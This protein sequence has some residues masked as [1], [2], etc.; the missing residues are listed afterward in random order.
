MD[1][2]QNLIRDFKYNLQNSINNDNN[3]PDDDAIPNTSDEPNLALDDTNANVYNTLSDDYDEFKKDIMD[4]K[5]KFRVEERQEPENIYSITLRNIYGFFFNRFNF[6]LVMW[7]LAIFFTIYGFLTIFTKTDVVTDGLLISR[8]V[9]FITFSF[10]FI[11]IFHSY[12]SSPPEIQSDFLYYSSELFRNELKDFNTMFYVT[13]FIIVLYIFSFLLGIPTGDEK[14]YSFTLLEN[15]AWVYLVLLVIINF[16]TYILNVSIVDLV[17]KYINDLFT[18]K[19]PRTTPPPTKKPV[20]YTLPPPTSPPPT[21][22][23]PTPSP[24]PTDPPDA[25]VFNI[26]NNLYTYEDAKNV[27]TALDARL[28]TY[29]QIEEAYNDGAE[30]CNYGWSTDQMA[31]FPTQ[32]DTWKK[33]QKNNG[34]KVN[35]NCGRPGI[36]GGFMAN[37][38]LK[39]GVNCFGKKPLPKETDL[40]NMNKPETQPQTAE[41]SEFEAKIKYWKENSD[42][43]L[44]ISGFNKNKWFENQNE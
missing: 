24:A 39:F 33:M 27:C 43:L 7:F 15:K 31:Y 5:H 29:E 21:T 23:P 26:S 9:D 35:N 1:Y 2:L 16:F 30:W 18:C 3:N 41:Q 17:Y 11:Y 4:L 20:C 34:G 22:A 44:N 14:P 8:V 32:L 13:F 12:Y 37:P 38:N 40:S 6:I 36:N 28:A 25:E 42:K 10:I 19:V